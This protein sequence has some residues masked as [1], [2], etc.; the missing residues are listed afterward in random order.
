M[1]KR[2]AGA[3]A[4]L[5]RSGGV[6]CI[7]M[8]AARTR[9]C[10]KPLDARRRAAVV[11]WKAASRKSLQQPPPYLKIGA[12]AFTTTTSAP[13]V[14]FVTRGHTGRLSSAVQAMPAHDVF[15]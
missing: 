11:R 2:E 12:L 1:E 7:G 8:P 4:Q 15:S 13:S 3:R 9:M 10:G 6:S 5:R 14:A